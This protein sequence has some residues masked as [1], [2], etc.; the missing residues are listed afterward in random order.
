M[1]TKKTDEEIVEQDDII[2]QEIDDGI[3][4]D[5]SMMVD[6]EAMGQQID[7]N[8][9]APFANGGGVPMEPDLKA[10]ETKMS[11]VAEM[12]KGGEI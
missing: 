8:T 1:S 6:P 2:Q 4:P 11:K 3:I 12:P 10:A 7:P 9:G 5:P